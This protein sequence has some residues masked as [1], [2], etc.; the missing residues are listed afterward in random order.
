M[1][2]L[3]AARLQA[4]VG[5]GLITSVGSGEDLAALQAGTAAPDGAAYVVPYQKSAGP[6]ERANGR[7]LQ[8]VEV[9]FLVAVCIRR[10]GDAKG[11]LR[12][13]ATDAIDDALSGRLLGWAPDDAHDPI[14]IRAVRSQPSGNGALW[15]VSTWATARYIEGQ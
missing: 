1:L 10:H 15:H 11:A 3:V 8:L 12:I 5:G 4:L 14:E 2:A 9:L 13:G 6:N 7:V